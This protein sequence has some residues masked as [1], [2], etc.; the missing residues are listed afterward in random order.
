MG[1]ADLVVDPPAE[2]G[3][4]GLLRRVENYQLVLRQAWQGDLR[5][6][7]HGDFHAAAFQG[8]Y[9]LVR[10]APIDAQ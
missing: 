6:A 2:H 4:G 9:D 3:H 10:D 5:V 1:A 7:G 8:G